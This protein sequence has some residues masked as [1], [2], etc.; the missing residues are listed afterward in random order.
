MLTYCFPFHSGDRDL[1]L[2]LAEQIRDLKAAE[3]HHC[4]MVYP[5]GT[6]HDDIESILRSA[7]HS[8]DKHPYV[9]Q[10]SGWPQ[11]PNEAFQQAALRI[12]A[13]PACGDFCWLET[14]IV[15]TESIALNA[16]ENAFRNCGHPLM[17]NVVDT[18]AMNTRQVV[19]RHMIGVGV[20]PKDFATY[21]PLVKYLDRMSSEHV[22]QGA[23]PMAFDAYFGA[24]T[25]QRCSE[26][27]LIQHFWRS[28]LFHV[29]QNGDIVAGETL[30][31]EKKVRAGVLLIH[32]CKDDSLMRIFSPH[33]SIASFDTTERKKESKLIEAM[34]ATLRPPVIDEI[35]IP[36]GAEVT[37]M[38]APVKTSTME[39]PR[40]G[41][42]SIDER[43]GKKMLPYPPEVWNR[44]EQGLPKPPFLYGQTEF[45]RWN[46]LMVA[47]LEKDG[48]KKLKDYAKLNLKLRPGNITAEALID[49]CVLA[50][51]AAGTMDW[52]KNLPP[53]WFPPKEIPPESNVV[54][55]QQPAPPPAA[56]A[57]PAPGGWS[58][59]APA[60]VT[61]GSS[62]ISDEM[63]QKMLAL[64]IKRGE[65]PAG[66][67]SA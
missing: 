15:L 30:S 26:T 32:G 56:P 46:Q 57:P 7:F 47:R 22:R 23:V 61:E 45:K 64:R 55:D 50:E 67:V 4:L 52:T 41:P 54:P 58:P 38:T 8:V 48:L 14:D 60:K 42:T 18:L 25:A 49:L 31:P 43:K 6:K 62:L 29:E 9:A 35:T 39:P 24:Y 65:I 27:P 2:A 63:K 33:R 66:T 19:G 44:D 5:D 53:P 13:D 51:R 10:L 36:N 34:D 28:K 11:G 12:S 16:I 20:Y 17:G 59:Q 3:N 21:C 40:T 1:A 37:T